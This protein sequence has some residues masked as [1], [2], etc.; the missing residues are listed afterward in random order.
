MARPFV[1]ILES[2]L[3]LQ[4]CSSLCQTNNW[5]S[6]PEI[7]SVYPKLESYIYSLHFAW[8]STTSILPLKVDVS[9][10]SKKCF[11]ESN[12]TCWILERTLSPMRTKVLNNPIQQRNVTKYP[13]SPS[14]ILIRIEPFT[15]SQLLQ[16]RT[17]WLPLIGPLVAQV[18]QRS[19]RLRSRGPRRTTGQTSPTLRRED[20]FRTA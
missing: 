2:D 18:P 15:T 12:T 1:L 7:N 16:P 6:V 19:T 3:D 20:A 10:A 4:Y 8:T 17:P 9:S 11:L 13:R 14:M 5:V